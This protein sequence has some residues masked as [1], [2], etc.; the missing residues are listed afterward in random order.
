MVWVLFVVLLSLGGSIA[1]PAEIVKALC[2][3]DL[4]A[5]T[6]DFRDWHTTFRIWARLCAV[7]H[8]EL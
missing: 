2:A 4:G 6:L 3:L 7:L 1:A 8:V 5:T